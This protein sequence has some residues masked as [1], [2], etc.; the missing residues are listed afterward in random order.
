[1]RGTLSNC[2][3]F[4]KL[5]CLLLSVCCLLLTND[6]QVEVDPEEAAELNVP[7]SPSRSAMR[8][9]PQYV[10]NGFPS[11][12]PQRTD[13]QSFLP[14]IP[15]AEENYG[16]IYNHPETEAEKTMHELWV[17]RRRQEVLC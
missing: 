11:I 15:K 9:A 3:K 6:H 16:M 1:L 13:Y 17:A 10:K 14:K 5:V 8:S 4:D 12:L 2:P 7:S